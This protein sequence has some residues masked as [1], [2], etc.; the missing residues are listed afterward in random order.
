M[1][2]R[3][4]PIGSKLNVCAAKSRTLHGA[5]VRTKAYTGLSRVGATSRAPQEWRS[6][7]WFVGSNPASGKTAASGHG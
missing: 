2:A 6:L 7:G 3:Y 5:A 4:A 1:R